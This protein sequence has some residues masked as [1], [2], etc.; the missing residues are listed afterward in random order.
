MTPGSGATLRDVVTAA[1]NTHLAL[2]YAIRPLVSD[3]YNASIALAKKDRTLVE[4]KTIRARES[5]SWSGESRGIGSNLQNCVLE[6]GYL[7]T[8]SGKVIFEVT[9]PFLRALDNLGI[10]NPVSIAWELVPLSFVVDWFLPVGKFL[11]NVVP[12]QGV[13]FVRGYTYTKMRG[14]TH[15]RYDVRHLPSGYLIT[16]NE[17]NQYKHRKMLTG[18][19]RYHVVVP[20][21]SLSRNQIA[22]GLALLWQAR[23]GRR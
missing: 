11:Q 7:A 20:D 4:V 19:P 3:V 22:S 14:Y 6:G 9:N 1:G 18:L 16:S 15:Y 2:T 5:R 12:P 13:E 17:A 23:E 21:I 8:C 10:L